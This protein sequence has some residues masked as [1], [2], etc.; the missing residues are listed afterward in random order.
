MQ[1]SD[2]LLNGHKWHVKGKDHE[3]ALQASAM[4]GT[5]YRPKR[6]NI[7]L[8]IIS[9]RPYGPKRQKLL[10]LAGKRQMQARS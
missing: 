8:G 6:P 1:A 2:L 9:A 5:A 10:G 7:V 4:L 3:V